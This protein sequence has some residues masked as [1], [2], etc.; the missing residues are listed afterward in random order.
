MVGVVGGAEVAAIGP[1][2]PSQGRYDLGR[3]SRGRCRRGPHQRAARVVWVV[4]GA[5]VA[6][7]RQ[8]GHARGNRDPCRAATGGVHRQRPGQRH[9]IAEVRRDRGE[10]VH[11]LVRQL[12]GAGEIA[13]DPIGTGVV[14][15][16]KAGRA[17]PV[18]H[19]ANVGGPRQ[20]VVVRVVRVV[21]EPVAHPQALIGGGH[22]LHQ[23]HRPDRRD[24]LLL[25]V[26]FLMHDRA[27]PLLGHGVSR[28]RL[29]DVG[30]PGILRRARRRIVPLRRQRRAHAAAIRLSVSG[31]TVPARLAASGEQ[32]G[33]QHQR[34]Q[35]QVGPRGRPGAL[36]S[37]KS[38]PTRH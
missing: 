27:H 6:S 4:G 38:A 29:A 17:E 31:V 3:F 8:A 37:V 36:Q 15:G 32:Q 30:T 5:E 7:R 12:G 26:R 18:V 22:D 16:Q 28:R 14:G 23:A 35:L 1:G 24:R 11:R 33:R 2:L 19:L 10:V 9:G 21:A 20:E 34:D 25:P 13:V